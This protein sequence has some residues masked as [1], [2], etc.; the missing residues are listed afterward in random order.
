M[1]LRITLSSDER[2]IATDQDIQGKLLEDVELQLGDGK[3]HDKLVRHGQI[4]LGRARL[5]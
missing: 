4:S 5:V 3:T 2:G 1:Y